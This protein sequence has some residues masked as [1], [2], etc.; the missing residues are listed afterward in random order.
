[1]SN[2]LT[3]KLEKYGR[4]F[5]YFLLGVDSYGETR[6]RHAIGCPNSRLRGHQPPHAMWETPEYFNHRAIISREQPYVKEFYGMT[7]KKIL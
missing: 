1:V 6:F 5:E 4:K 3:Q 2:K 7:Y